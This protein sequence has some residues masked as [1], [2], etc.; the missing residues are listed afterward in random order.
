MYVI[1]KLRKIVIKVNIA[2]LIDIF[3]NELLPNTNSKT[4]NG[5][6]PELLLTSAP[7]DLIQLFCPCVY[8]LRGRLN[9]SAFQS[10]YNI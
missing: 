5:H 10:R 1:D 4:H 3:T 7:D 8:G 9:E 6:P 2:I